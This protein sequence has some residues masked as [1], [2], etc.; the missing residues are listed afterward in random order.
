MGVVSLAVAS[1]LL[2]RIEPFVP[3]LVGALALAPAVAYGFLPW[4]GFEGWAGALPWPGYLVVA[5]PVLVLGL[6]SGERPG[7]P[8]FFRRM[9]GFSTKR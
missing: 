8:R 1:V 2:R 7:L 9:P 5:V 3:W 4:G 6:S